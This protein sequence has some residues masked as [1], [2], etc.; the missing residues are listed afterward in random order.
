MFYHLFANATYIL[1]FPALPLWPD[2]QQH[3]FYDLMPNAQYSVTLLADNVSKSIV[4]VTTDFGEFHWPQNQIPFCGFFCIAALA[5]FLLNILRINHWSHI[6]SAP[7]CVDCSNCSP[8]KP[9]VYPPK[10]QQLILILW[11]WDLYIKHCLCISF[12]W[13]LICWGWANRAHGLSFK[14]DKNCSFHISKPQ[15]RLS[16]NIFSDIITLLP[17]LKGS[18]LTVLTLIFQDCRNVQ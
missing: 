1:S 7:W 3:T 15:G 5:T 12:Y 9:V 18:N 6:C 4:Q 17:K 2:D 16:T 8:V 13:C 11:V 14:M 10:T